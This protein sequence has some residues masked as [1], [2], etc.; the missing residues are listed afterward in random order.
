MPRD[1]LLAA[2]N[3]RQG[4]GSGIGGGGRDL[5]GRVLWGFLGCRWSKSR[6][7]QG[8]RS[9]RNFFGQF[10]H[11]RFLREQFLR[12]QW[13][14]EQFLSKQMLCNQFLCDY[15]VGGLVDYPL[16][17]FVTG[18]LPKPTTTRGLFDMG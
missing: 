10:S 7:C 11:E 16:P 6:R 15:P 5:A 3:R 13:L 8:S 1:W 18:R 4:W 17:P 14:S 12:K 2:E 9:I